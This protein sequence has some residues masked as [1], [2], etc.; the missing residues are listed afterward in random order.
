M[1]IHRILAAIVLIPLVVA[2]LFFVPLP[3]FS[4]TIILVCGL[5][6]WEWTQFLHISKKYLKLIFSFSTVIL[7]CILYLVPDSIEF[8]MNLYSII[9]FLSI[10]WWLIALFLVSSYPVT[11]KYWCNSIFIKLLFAFFT[12]APF[13]ISMVELRAINYN[14]NSYTG[15]I[16]LLYVFVLVWATD[17]GAY[18]VGRSFGK[19]KLAAKVS[20]G[21]T[22]EGFIGGI[23]VA[24][25]ISLIA[26][27]LN[28]FDMTFS[29]FFISSLLA[30]LV[31]VLGDLTE[32][33]FKREANIKDSGHL[34]PGHGG[35]LDRI[36]SLTAAVPVFATLAFYLL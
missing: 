14:S 13:F 6:A 9:L 7:L 16:W 18:F 15:A 2:V 27:M 20:P 35:I 1:L 36:D 30:I 8:K 26:Y 32:S 19:R 4:F 22:I 33:M 28:M 29:T 5:A 10:I 11:T 21:K 31:S 25:V 12:L 17:T 3:V 34:I 23:S 24:I